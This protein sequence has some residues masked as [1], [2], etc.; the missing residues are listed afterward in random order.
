MINKQRIQYLTTDLDWIE[1]RK[2]DTYIRDVHVGYPVYLELQLIVIFFC[3][4]ESVHETFP[5]SFPLPF[6]FSVRL[7]RIT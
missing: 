2:R 4:D 5:P 1:W 6:S 3:N 7:L